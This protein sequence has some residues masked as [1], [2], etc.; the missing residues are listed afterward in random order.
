LNYL[1]IFFFP[2]LQPGHRTPRKIVVN[3][4]PNG[5]YEHVT[6][7]L[8]TGINVVEVKATITKVASKFVCYLDQGIGTYIE[9]EVHT[10]QEGCQIVI[11]KTEYLFR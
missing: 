7:S 6:L 1:I 2:S 5:Q 3:T 8:K 11:N 4:K 10:H 9:S